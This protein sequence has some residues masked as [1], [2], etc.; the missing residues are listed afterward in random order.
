MRGAVLEACSITC[1][2]GSPW[3]QEAVPT[4]HTDGE[5]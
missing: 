2:K 5:S 3:Q 1:S 4:Q